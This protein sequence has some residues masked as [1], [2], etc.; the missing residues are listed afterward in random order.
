M[1]KYSLDEENKRK[2]GART[3]EWEKIS[4]KNIEKENEADII[5]LNDQQLG[6]ILKYKSFESYVINDLLRETDNLLELTKEQQN[7]INALDEALKRVKKY[8]GMLIDV[9]IFQHIKMRKNVC[10][11]LCQIILWERQ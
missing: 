8:N 5:E 6:A 10:K 4:D 7:Y 3:E 11:A 9:L 1:S 2:Y